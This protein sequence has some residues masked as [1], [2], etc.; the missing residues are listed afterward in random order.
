M[1]LFAAGHTMGALD[2]WSPPGETAVLQSMRTFRFDASGVSRTYWD[3]YIG[4]GLYISI[5]LF[6]NAV[7]LWQLGATARAEPERAR[8]VVAAFLVASIA[9][10]YVAWRYIFMLPALF[11]LACAVCLAMAVFTSR[12]S[13]L[14]NVDRSTT[15]T[16]PTPSQP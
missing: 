5:L 2:S 6:L 4:F 16:T 13:S 14:S 10:T 12:P 15:G 7:V 9:G 8:P 3:F 11:S 1:F